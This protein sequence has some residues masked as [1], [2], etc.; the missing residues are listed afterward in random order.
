MHKSYSS[1]ELKNYCRTDTRDT[2]PRTRCVEPDRATLSKIAK[3]VEGAETW[4][5]LAGMSLG[6][7]AN[8]HADEDA[9]LVPHPPS[10]DGSC[11]VCMADAADPDQYNLCGDPGCVD[12]FAAKVRE[13]LQR[14]AGV[15]A[16]WVKFGTVQEGR[17]LPLAVVRHVLGARAVNDILA[18]MPALVAA[19][20]PVLAKVKPCPTCMAAG[21]GMC[22]VS[23]PTGVLSSLLDAKKPEEERVRWTCGL[24][25]RFTAHMQPAGGLYTGAVN[26]VLLRLLDQ[27]VV[28]EYGSIVR[29]PY[30]QC[31]S[32]HT[33]I[34]KGTACFEM[35]CAVC[36]HKFCWGCGL[37][38]DLCGEYP[39]TT[40]HW[41]R[42]PC[43][44][45][46]EYATYALHTE[47]PRPPRGAP[48]PIFLS[49]TAGGE[50]EATGRIVPSR[51]DIEEWAPASADERAL[52]ATWLQYYSSLSTLVGWLVNN[53]A[54]FGGERTA[55]D[56]VVLS[57]DADYFTPEEGRALPAMLSAWDRFEAARFHVLTAEAVSRRSL[58]DPRDG[59]GV[60]VPVLTARLTEMMEHCDELMELVMG[61]IAGRSPD[62]PVDLDAVIAAHV[63]GVYLAR[64]KAVN[65]TLAGLY[66]RLTANRAWRAVHRAMLEPSTLA[67]DMADLSLPIR[68]A[69]RL[70]FLSGAHWLRLRYS[71]VA[72]RHFQL[73][74]KQEFIAKLDALARAAGLSTPVRA[75][76]DQEEDALLTDAGTHYLGLP[77]RDFPMSSVGATS[78]LDC[79]ATAREYWRAHPES[80]EGP[81]R[82]V[83]M[84][85]LRH[86]QASTAV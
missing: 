2:G 20:V 73:T 63:D 53:P 10:T 77:P 11:W 29:E 33:A 25:H 43:R 49:S 46:S 69:Q 37:P 84:A 57:A 85:R 13:D 80:E 32:C 68:I 22:L 28:T 62:A 23:K 51:V 67:D 30:L 36:R 17:T 1:A 19:L 50:Q 70:Y 76:R 48:M 24:G 79:D 86:G 59:A 71:R 44:T 52:K 3:A 81:R 42:R 27:D 18:A 64:L 12:L 78:Y 40:D 54:E 8:V 7:I 9:A 4:G 26:A 45:A 47:V 83:V 14:T 41:A 21:N 34:V 55:E 16:P 39:D 6:A 58:P 66:H 60:V 72:V 35:T 31:P 82:P 65:Q 5:D 74:R 75:M 61:P 15:S 56:T 38:M